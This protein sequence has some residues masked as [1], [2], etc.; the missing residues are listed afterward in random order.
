MELEELHVLKRQAL[1]PNDSNAVTRERVSIRCGLED[2]A[3]STGGENDRLRLE[4]VQLAGRE[5]VGND[6][7]GL[8]NTIDLGHDQVENVE[9]VEEVDAELDAVLVERLKDHVARAVGG[10]AGAANR[11]LAV[12]TSVTTETT[13]VDL[14]VFGAVEGQAHVL[15]VDY[16]VDCLF[17]EDLSRRLQ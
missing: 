11:R 9:L 6:S 15:A 3:E 2:L 13:L 7:G 10:V 12:L 16:G 4:D 8:F 1:A 17:G 5:F 14:A